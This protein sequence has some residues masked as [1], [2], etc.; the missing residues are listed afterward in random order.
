MY[1][2]KRSESVYVERRRKRGYTERAKKSGRGKETDG[3]S[4]HG[5]IERDTYIHTDRQTKTAN[6]RDR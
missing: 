5:E 3:E 6:D 4:A 1:T 2:E